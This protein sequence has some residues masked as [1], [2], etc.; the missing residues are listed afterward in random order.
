MENASKAL[1]IAGAVLLVI[2]I[3]GIGMYILQSTSG[4]QDQATQSMSELEIQNFNQKFD[5]FD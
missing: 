1:L 5:K 2:A 4:I 3:I